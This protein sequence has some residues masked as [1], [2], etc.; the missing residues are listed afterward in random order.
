MLSLQETDP[1]QRLA[2]YRA[3]VEHCGG[4]QLKSTCAP[5]EA[6]RRVFRSLST[7]AETDVGRFHQFFSVVMFAAALAISLAGVWNW[8]GHPGLGYLVLASVGSFAC[9]LL[10]GRRMRLGR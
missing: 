7:F 10:H 8:L 1:T 5:L 9:L 2:I 6:S 4:C 3:P